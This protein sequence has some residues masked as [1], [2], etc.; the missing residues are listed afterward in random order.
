MNWD[1]A[2]ERA[3]L[4]ESVGPEEYN[5]KFAAHL[6]QTTVGGIRRVNTRF[7]LL[8]AVVGTDKAFSTLKQAEEYR[9]KGK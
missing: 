4:I 9:D 6:K 7:G 1:N 2:E 5:R 3:R 8:F